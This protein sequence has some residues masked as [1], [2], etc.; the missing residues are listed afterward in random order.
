M[1]PRPSPAPHAGAPASAPSAQRC[2]P[3]FIETTRFNER[4]SERQDVLTETYCFNE[5][6]FPRPGARPPTRA[7]S[8]LVS[9]EK[10]PHSRNTG[11]SDF[12]TE[13]PPRRRS[14]PLC[15]PAPSRPRTQAAPSDAA[16]ADRQTPNPSRVARSATLGRGRRAER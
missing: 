6:D 1:T 10:V 15:A 7:V 11:S 5:T 8:L 2:P 12:E 4:E 3:R 13:P 16:L 14:F 9:R